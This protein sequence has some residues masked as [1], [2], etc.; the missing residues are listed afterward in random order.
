MGWGGISPVFD[1]PPAT[2]NDVAEPSVRCP[3]FLAGRL[4]ALIDSYLGVRIDSPERER[5]CAMRFDT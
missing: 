4:G 5:A 3:D 1:V 2:F